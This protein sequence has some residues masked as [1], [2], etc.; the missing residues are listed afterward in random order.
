LLVSEKDRFSI[1]RRDRS[2]SPD[3]PGACQLEHDAA[4]ILPD[5]T[6]NAGALDS[7]AADVVADGVVGAWSSSVPV[8]SSFLPTWGVN[9]DAFAISR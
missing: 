1:G 3:N 7:D 8:T 9:A 5:S 2:A 6:L 4:T